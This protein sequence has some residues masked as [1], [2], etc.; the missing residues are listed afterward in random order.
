MQIN[1][2]RKNTLKYIFYFFCLLI[3]LWHNTYNSLG[4]EKTSIARKVTEYEE[5]IWDY[6][7]GSV[8]YALTQLQ[9]EP[10]AKLYVIAYGKYERVRRK[11]QSVKYYLVNCRGLT[12]NRIAMLEGGERE[13]TLVEL[14]LAPREAKEPVPTSIAVKPST[15]KRAYTIGAVNYSCEGCEPQGWYMNFS[16]MNYSKI[17]QQKVILFFTKTAG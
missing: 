8:D 4:Q 5:S 14:W 3:I 9:N 6:E 15:E 1:R 2:M 7:Q 12:S 16:Q 10:D 13:K 11:T 17:Q